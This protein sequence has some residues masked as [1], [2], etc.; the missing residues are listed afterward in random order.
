VI[1]GITTSKMAS[2]TNGFT[3]KSKLAHKIG[4][5]FQLLHLCFRGTAIQMGLLNKF[6]TLIGSGK[7]KMASFT[8]AIP[9]SQL[10]DKIETKFKLLFFLGPSIQW[11]Y[12]YSRTTIP[13]V[14]NYRW[15]SS[16]Q[17]HSYLSACRNHSNNCNYVFE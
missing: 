2:T 14:R 7:S 1:T 15:R 5:Q 11:D 16:N 17:K 6:Y 9:I 13:E 8:P 10:V 12:Q 4:T 3:Y